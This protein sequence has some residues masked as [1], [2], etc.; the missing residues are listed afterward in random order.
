MRIAFVTDST[1]DI[2]YE[3]VKEH[4]LY[5]VPN[6]IVMDGKSVQD[7]ENF[8]RQDFYNRM[9][10]MTVPPTTAT[11]SP[12][13]FYQ[14][15]SK[16]FQQG[17]NQIVSLHASSLLSGIFNAA[18]LAAKSFGDRVTV[19]DSKQVSLAMGFQV[20]AAKEAEQ[21]G[22]SLPEIMDRIEKVGQRAHLI[23]MLDSLTYIRRSGRISWLRAGLGSLLSIKLLVE[24]KDGFVQKIGEV[25]TR[26]KGIARVEELLTSLG[27]LER[28]AILHTNA[29]MDAR[30]LL[31]SL[32]LEPAIHPLIVN[33][34]TVIGT[35]VGP[36]GLGFACI[37]A[38]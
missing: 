28:L 4:E 10:S 6:I 38:S 3:L 7:D 11:A 13:T 35:H 9:P 19:I 1:C 8:S 15:Y 34:T 2:P 14:L 24:V 22:L 33:V 18:S 37:T 5:V 27:S 29:E 26:S 30:Q 20:L 25:R 21:Q 36:N 12:G 17:I 23:A 32:R 16:L 31:T